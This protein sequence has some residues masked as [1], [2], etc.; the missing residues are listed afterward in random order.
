MKVLIPSSVINLDLGR[1]VAGRP[2]RKKSILDALY[3]VVSCLTPPVYDFKDYQHLRGFK[4]LSSEQMN[5]MTR[6]RFNEVKNIL[7]DSNA[8]SM[9]PIVLS[10]DLFIPGIKNI[11]YKLSPWIIDQSKYAKIEI[12]PKYDAR[13]VQLK[14]EWSSGKKEFEKL[15]KHIEDAMILSNISID[16]D[17]ARCYLKSLG[18][19][20]T[21][22]VL[23]KNKS[24]VRSYI[25]KLEK[26]IEDI[27]NREFNYSVSRSNH[28]VNS[29]FTSMKRE[30]RYFL[31]GDGKSM[32]EVDIKTSHPYTLATILTEEFFTQTS[33]GYN[34]Y[35]MYPQVHRYFKHSCE[36][37]EY[38]DYVEKFIRYMVIESNV[39]ND[40]YIEYYTYKGDV[41]TNIKNP[42]IDTFVSY[43]CGRFW[44]KKGIQDYRNL[45][46]NRDIYQSI[47]NEIGMSREGVK[48]QFK[49]YINYADK[50]K[51]INVE[52]IKHLEKRYKEVSQ[53]IQYLSNLNYF[54]SPL[55]YL[56]QRC[57]SYLFLLHG[58]E[59]L[60]RNKI[61]YIT[62]HDSV[63]CHEDK[64][65]EV[66]FLLTNTINNLTGLRPGIKFKK[67]DNPFLTIEETSE[68]IVESIN[69]ES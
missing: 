24:Q 67:L 51:R 26:T 14:S 33:E 29:V 36:S 2:Q 6:N 50:H 55:S 61:P 52:L 64:K 59:S 23:P 22:K 37:M 12:D 20:L 31:K 18:E 25:Q 66:Q 62:I 47:G 1:L 15:Y 28:R 9:G 46:F 34:L 42:L 10:D 57:E 49:L 11:G 16:G 60:S 27:E 38:Q 19:I 65:L 4:P 48:D 32:V 21:S 58:C 43:M 68:K 8:T 63:M 44:R 39:V 40:N 53:L 13:K 54:K 30:L 56:I 3:Y 5:R 41:L 17:A 45:N 7:M 69:S 35:S